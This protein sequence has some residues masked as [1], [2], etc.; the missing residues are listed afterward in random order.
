M[1]AP[2]KRPTAFMPG[3]VPTLNRRGFMF[4]SLD[5]FSQ[6][7]VRY[8]TVC[9]GPVLDMGCAYG[10]ASRAALEAGATVHACDMEAGHLAILEAETPEA[11]RGRLT[12]HVGTLPDVDFPA[13]SFA[14]ILC[15]RVFHF[16][17]GEE[18]RAALAR[19]HDWLQ[20]GGRLYLVADTPYTG[21]WAS[22]AAA[23]E[24]RKAAGE[25]WPGFI[26]DIAVYLPDGSRPEGMLPY[27]HPLDPDILARECHRAGLEVI[28]SGYS[29]CGDDLHSRKHA[30]VLA[31]RSA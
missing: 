16:L 9:E 31:L 17:R 22:G 24:A 26:A 4:E 1:S 13:Q 7:F 25:A 15:S 11:L 21:F 23:S 2:S 19:M 28:D 5:R 6:A 14:A 8:A 29:G 18:I 27:L 20:E 10:V 12:T 30:G 3:L